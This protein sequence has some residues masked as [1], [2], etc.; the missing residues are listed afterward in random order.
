MGITSAGTQVVPGSTSGNFINSNY[1]HGG[2]SN[3][4]VNELTDTQV[5]TLNQSDGPMV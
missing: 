1:D 5:T 2:C 3:R 4:N